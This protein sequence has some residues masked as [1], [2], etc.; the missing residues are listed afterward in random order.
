MA[1]PILDLTVIIPN[2]NTRGLLRNCIDSI[3]RHTKGVVF[4][5]ICVDGNSPDGSADMVAEEFPDVVLVRNKCNDS[6][7]RS[8]NQGIKLSHGRYVCLLDSDTMLIGNTFQSLVQFMDQNPEAA[9]C[10][11]KL[12]N[13]DGTL[14][15]DI[16][17]FAGLGI[18][19]LQTLNWHRMFPNSRLM[20]KYYASDFDFSR[21]QQVEAI[22]TTVFLLRRSTWQNAGLLDERFR[23]AMVDLAYEFMLAKKGYKVFYTPCA[24]VIHFGSQT[25]NQDVLKTLREQ[26]QG[27][28]DFSEAYDYFGKNALLKAFVRFGIRARYYLK[29][30]GYYVSSDKRVI[31]GPGRPSKEQ[32]EHIAMLVEARTPAAQHVRREKAPVASFSQ[33]GSD[34]NSV[35]SQ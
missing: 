27:L 3:Y 23:W 2:Y 19:F 22:G 11:P 24:E 14:Q 34:A 21:P 15:H 16:R 12:L 29:V 10:G 5:I 8:V 7:A 20:A 9:A 35:A 13:P 28:I 18:F 25:A 17:R 33:S 31:K 30:L 1:K 26:C 6:Y 4:E 32:A